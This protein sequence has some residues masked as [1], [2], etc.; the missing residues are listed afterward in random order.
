MH[1]VISYGCRKV[2]QF[3]MMVTAINSQ[4][5]SKA[6]SYLFSSSL[7]LCTHPKENRVVNDK[8]RRYKNI[9]HQRTMPLVKNFW[10]SVCRES[11]IITRCVF[12]LPFPRYIGVVRFTD[13][14]S[15]PCSLT[16]KHTVA[17]IVAVVVIFGDAQVLFSLQKPIKQRKFLSAK[18][19]VPNSLGGRSDLRYKFELTFDVSNWFPLTIGLVTN[20]T[21]IRKTTRRG[22]WARSWT[23]VSEMWRIYSQTTQN[24]AQKQTVLWD[25]VKAEL[26]AIWT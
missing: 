17:V 18:W 24:A 9:K 20:G 12:L 25:S 5:K 26:E 4:Q 22:R 3:T 15:L 8:N 19:V 21:D 1:D 16:E 10:Q 7:F 11:K 6:F 2:N 13:L 23:L 14:L